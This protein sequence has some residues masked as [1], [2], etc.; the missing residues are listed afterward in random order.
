MKVKIVDYLFIK[1]IIN[2]N[3]KNYLLVDVRTKNEVLHGCIKTSIH[4]PLHQIHSE[5]SIPTSGFT[6]KYNF[7]LR[8]KSPLIFYCQAGVR[9]QK[10]A[11]IVS[12]L[13]FT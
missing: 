11:E 13:G 9:S 8:K 7:D 10:A 2:A 1:R 4:I 3:A 6:T 5:F 12:S